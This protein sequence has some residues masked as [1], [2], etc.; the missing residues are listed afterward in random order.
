MSNIVFESPS[1]LLEVVHHGTVIRTV[2]YSDFERSGHE[3]VTPSMYW[4]M[5]KYIQRTVLDP[6]DNNE[7]DERIDNAIDMY[8]EQTCEARQ[9]G[10]VTI[11]ARLRAEYKDASSK[12]TAALNWVLDEYGPQSDIYNPIYPECRE[13]AKKMVKKYSKR[14]EKLANMIDEEEE[15]RGGWESDT[16]TM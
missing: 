15:W 14:A 16:D 6:L 5:G 3:C 9:T 1:E 10:H 8:Y 4:W 12:D 11:L 7:I 13:F 2:T